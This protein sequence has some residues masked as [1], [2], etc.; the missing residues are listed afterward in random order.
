MDEPSVPDVYSDVGGLCRS[1]VSSFPAPEHKVSGKK[2][3]QI[4]QENVVAEAVALLKEGKYNVQQI[5]D[6]LHFP[7]PSYFCRYFRKAAGKTPRA[8]MLE[9]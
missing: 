4:I 5:S 7:S 3:L 8:Y 1:A 6:L 9:G 2:A